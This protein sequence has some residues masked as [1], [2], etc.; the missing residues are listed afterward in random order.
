MGAPPPRSALASRR[1]RPLFALT[2][3]LQVHLIRA[4]ETPS[5]TL[6]TKPIP[7]GLHHR[8]V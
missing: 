5:E 2:Y 4:R 3:L 7:V 6:L 1:A 8:A